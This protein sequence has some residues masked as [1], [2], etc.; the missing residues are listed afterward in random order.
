[1]DSRLLFNPTIPEG[2]PFTSQHLK[3]TKSDSPRSDT[4]IHQLKQY[5][6]HYSLSLKGENFDL[7][8]GRNNLFYTLLVFLNHIKVKN[9]GLLGY[10]PYF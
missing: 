1:M 4:F 3:L 9:F 7:P 5:P 2:K 10:V 8:P 6:P